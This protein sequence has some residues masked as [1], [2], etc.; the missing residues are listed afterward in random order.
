VSGRG[1]GG[2]RVGEGAEEGEGGGEVGGEVVEEG[3]VGGCVGVDRNGGVGGH[4][5]GELVVGRA[6]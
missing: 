1:G 2:E 6:G 5:L 3:G 4:G